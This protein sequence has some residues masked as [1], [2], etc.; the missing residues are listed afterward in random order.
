MTALST[1]L[2]VICAAAF[3]ALTMLAAAPASADEA[4]KSIEGGGLKSDAIT[5]PRDHASGLPTGRRMHTAEEI[6]EGYDALIE[7]LARLK[8][9]AIK[10]TGQAEELAR[11][12]Q[13]DDE[14]ASEGAS[15][16]QDMLSQ[17][18]DATTMFTDQI[19]PLL[20]PDIVKQVTGALAEK[21]RQ[22]TATGT[23]SDGSSADVA[24]ALEALQQ[25][26]AEV[27][28]ALDQ[29]ESSARGA[30][31]AQVSRSNIANN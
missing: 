31:T 29:L 5:S 28:D 30:K 18:D 25:Q 6:S 12:A 4:G 14:A 1:R 15:A 11:M 13:E 17:V 23:F 24:A 2:S 26:I 19:A 9:G 3:G 21:K 22:L 7:E 16:A 27:Q 20:D 10:I 8:D